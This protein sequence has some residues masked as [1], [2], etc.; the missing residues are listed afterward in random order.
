VSSS[1]KSL[2]VTAVLQQ[3]FDRQDVHVVK[4]VKTLNRNK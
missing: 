4:H 1:S 3:T 2:V